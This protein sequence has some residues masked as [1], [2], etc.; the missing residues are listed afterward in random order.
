MFSWKKKAQE[1]D[2]TLK[3]ES[4]KFKAA[5]EDG[6]IKINPSPNTVGTNV[7]QPIEKIDIP[8]SE[9]EKIPA[10]EIKKYKKADLEK[11]AAEGKGVDAES[12]QYKAKGESGKLQYPTKQETF[13]VNVKQPGTSKDGEAAGKTY[14]DPGKT[15]KLEIPTKETKMPEGGMVVSTDAKAGAEFKP[16]GDKEK[17]ITKP[18]EFKGGE[19]QPKSDVSPTDYMHKYE[20]AKP[21]NKQFGKINWF[22]RDAIT[23]EAQEAVSA[24][25]KKIEEDHPDWADDRA[26]A[27]AYRMMREKGYDIPKKSSIS[28]ETANIIIKAALDCPECFNKVVAYV[29]S[30]RKKA[31]VTREDLNTLYQS[32][33]IT[34]PTDILDAMV[35]SAAAGVAGSTS[36]AGGSISMPTMTGLKSSLT[37]KEAFRE[38]EEHEKK[39]HVES[40]EEETAEALGE[41]EK[42]GNPS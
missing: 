12:T 27:A 8:I 31:A 6:G 17:I 11:R 34:L 38:M 10:A 23:E 9:A 16:A 35:A 20:V 18:K 40:E 5:G 19:G 42:S 33:G 7:Q 1:V 22:K 32:K 30:L 14:K 26:Q 39:H 3:P 28:N 2:K 13:P 4:E 24:K 37:E 36:S 15:E 25:I 41:I 29:N 21:L